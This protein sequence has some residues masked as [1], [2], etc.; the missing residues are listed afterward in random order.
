QQNNNN[1]FASTEHLQHARYLLKLCKYYPLVLATSI[2]GLYY[3]HF[4]DEKLNF[5]ERIVT[6]PRSA[7]GKKE[8]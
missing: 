2:T 4:A 8:S 5:R 6:C 1:K 7:G 3:P